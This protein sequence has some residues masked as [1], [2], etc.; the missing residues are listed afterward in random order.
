M[1]VTA[2]GEA[3]SLIIMHVFIVVFLPQAHAHVGSGHE[4]SRS[5]RGNDDG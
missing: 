2:H 1:D 5:S 4:S 3:Y